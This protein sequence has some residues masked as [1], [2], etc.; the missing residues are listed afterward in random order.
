MDRGRK[1]FEALHRK[2]SLDCLEEMVGRNMNVKSNSCE[3]SD[4]KRSRESFYRLTVY[5]HH[6]EQNF[7]R[8]INTKDASGVISEGNEGHVIAN[9]KK[10]NCCYKMAEILTEFCSIV[11]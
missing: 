5:I 9:W 1:N 3:G 4:E 2:K 7:G 8:N 11:G 6:H 10:D